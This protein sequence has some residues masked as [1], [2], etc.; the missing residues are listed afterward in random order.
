MNPQAKSGLKHKLNN[1]LGHSMLISMVN[2]IHKA[3]N[4]WNQVTPGPTNSKKGKHWRIKEKES[5]DKKRPRED[6]DS[7]L[8]S[9]VE[10]Q[11]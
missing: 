9:P 7:Q 5:R 8:A 11:L 4:K 10:E 2:S 6:L 3:G 1:N